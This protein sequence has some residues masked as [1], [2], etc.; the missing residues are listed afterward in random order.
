MLPAGH[1]PFTSTHAPEVR[2]QAVGVPVGHVLGVQVLPGAGFV[3][4]GQLVP[5]KVKHAPLG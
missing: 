2:Q 3:P 1:A 4:V 5:T